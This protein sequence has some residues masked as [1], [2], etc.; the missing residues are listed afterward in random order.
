MA[1]IRG[2]FIWFEN[3]TRDVQAALGFYGSV[4]GWRTQ[5]WD[6]GGEPYHMFANGETPLAGAH[7]IPPGADQP[8]AWL[9]YIGTPDVKETTTLAESLGAKVWVRLMEIPSVGTM[10]VL[11]DPQGAMFAAYQPSSVESSEACAEVKPGDFSWHEL[12]TTDPDAALAFYQ[13]LFGWEK[14]G[15]HDM[16]HMGMYTEFGIPGRA[17]GGIYTKPA[18]MAGPPAWLYYVRT[19]DLAGS[20]SRVKANGG[21]VVLEPIEVPGGDHV[22]VFTDQQGAFFAMHEK[23]G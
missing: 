18:E 11:S 22:A 7:P 15:V 12:A 20:V 13:Q 19:A 17:L 3:L 10:S 21:T 6:G 5:R 4:I 9:G 16:G 23:K 14:Q 8:P 1:D 2:R